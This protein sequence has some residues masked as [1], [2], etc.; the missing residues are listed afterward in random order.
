MWSKHAMMLPILDEQTNFERLTAEAMDRALEKWQEEL[1][2]YSQEF[3]TL[4]S[5][6][7][8]IQREKGYFH[9]LHEIC[10][11]P[12]T[13][14]D[15]AAQLGEEAFRLEAFLS[16][17]NLRASGGKVVLTGSGSS[18]YVGECLWLQLQAEMGISVQALPSGVLLTHPGYCFLAGQPTLVVSFAR[19][20]NSPESLGVLDMHQERGTE[21]HFLNITCN[22]QGALAMS[23]P[24]SDRVFNFILHP[25]THDESLV[26][27]SSFSNMMLTAR[28]LGMLQSPAQ[29]R[30]GIALLASV[31]G[32]F[33]QEKT[34]VLAQMARREFNSVLFLGSGGQF[35][36]AEESALK[37]LEMTEGR[38]HSFPESYLGL[39]HGPMS[40]IHADTLVV[41]YLDSDPH[42][43][44][45]EIDLI[46]EL[47]RKQLGM[48]KVLVGSNIP[49]DILHP[50]DLALE[51][52]LTEDWDGGCLPVLA[53]LVGQLLGFF[54]CMHLG[55][56]PDSPSSTGVINRVVEQFKIHF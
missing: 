53:T 49:A 2:Q 11:Q 37:M 23:H 31:A 40:A 8:A 14:L 42:I 33:L 29:Y 13:W 28:F 45:H 27:T 3:S 21:C 44:A 12:L 17:M 52:S 35:G 18:F 7:E 10:Q 30:K 38:M 55:L 22:S 24:D 46:S 5:Q 47:N 43:R 15:T 16:R 20:G 54:R 9:T 1:G 50:G 19:S 26:M 34:D 32:Q 39:R 4:F 25:R 51:F 36:A 6:S 56:Q 41:C 48:Q